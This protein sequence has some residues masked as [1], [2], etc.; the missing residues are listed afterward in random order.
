MGNVEIFRVVESGPYT[1][2]EVDEVLGKFTE[3]QLELDRA[4][5]TIAST[6]TGVLAA[7]RLTGMSEISVERGTLSDRFVILSDAG[8]A[9]WAI[10]R[11]RKNGK[12]GRSSGVHALAA[13]IAAGLVG[14]L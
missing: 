11:G 7:H 2:R 14:G 6:A 3:V 9:A 13:G 4:A 5:A 8:G 10:E 1:G 12:H